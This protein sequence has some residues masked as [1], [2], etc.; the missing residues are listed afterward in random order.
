MY[1]EKSV[2]YMSVLKKEECGIHECVEKGG[3]MY[4]RRS[5]GYMSGLKKRVSCI[6]GGVWDT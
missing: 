2:G 4:P 1:P 3:V 5:V 6:P